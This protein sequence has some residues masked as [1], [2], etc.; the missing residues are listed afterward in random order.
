MAE[1]RKYF[2]YTDNDY[3]NR[4]RANNDEKDSNKR[5]TKII[6]TDLKKTSVKSTTVANWNLF[7]K[8]LHMK[9]ICA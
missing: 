7:E 1:Y 3:N 4:T 9:W 8:L 5:L 2:M 6:I